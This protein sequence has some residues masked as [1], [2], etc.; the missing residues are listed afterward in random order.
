MPHPAVPDALLGPLLDVA[1]DVLRGLAPADVPPALRALAGFDR[2]GLAN[3]T[4]RQQLRRAFD[5]DEDFRARVTEAFV[6][7][8]E[9]RAV[10]DG[11]APAGAPEAASDAADRSDLPWWTSALYAAE[12]D[13]AD[14]GLGVACAEDR[15]RRAARGMLD[16]VR[17]AGMRIASAEEAQRRA[18]TALEDLRSELARAEDELRD[19]R[20]GRRDR[21]AQ[22][23]R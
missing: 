18:E 20:R 4:A 11:W 6:A 15:H 10:L 17:A 22:V 5:L 8:P 9:V 16:D 7:R 13:G 12:P 21:E 3:A 19:E 1:A 2:R 23:E 14:F